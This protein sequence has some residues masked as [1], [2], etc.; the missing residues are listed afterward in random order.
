MSV[1][2]KEP[3][4]IDIEVLGDDRDEIRDKAHKWLDEFFKGDGYVITSEEYRQ[5]AWSS[6]LWQGNFKAVEQNTGSERDK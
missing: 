1:Y 6:R 3:A 2:F 4:S 5:A